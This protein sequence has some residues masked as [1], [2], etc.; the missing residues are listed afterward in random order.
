M[1]KTWI[2]YRK[3]SLVSETDRPTLYCVSTWLRELRKR[4]LGSFKCGTTGTSFLTC[5]V[6]IVR[7]S[8]YGYLKE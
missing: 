8:S 1:S 4:T 6:G 2:V 3:H 5:K 7:L